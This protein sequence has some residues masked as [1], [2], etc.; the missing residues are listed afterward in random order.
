MALR[1]LEQAQRVN[2]LETESA[3]ARAREVNSGYIT[4][5]ANYERIC[6]SNFVCIHNV[7]RGGCFRALGSLGFSFL[8]LLVNV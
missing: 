6:L 3:C 2:A 4:N 7:G 5:G 8:R 1:I